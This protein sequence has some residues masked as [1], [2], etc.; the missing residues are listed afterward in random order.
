MNGAV[1]FTGNKENGAALFTACLPLEARQPL[2]RLSALK[3]DSAS[4]AFRLL[5]G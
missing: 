2:H 4:Q 5:A 3:K 1:Y